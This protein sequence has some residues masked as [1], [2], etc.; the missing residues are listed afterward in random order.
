[1]FT[2]TAATFNWVWSAMAAITLWRTVPARSARLGTGRAVTVRV[3]EIAPSS[4]SLM[5]TPSAPQRT[6]AWR[7]DLLGDW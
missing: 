1:M 5:S 4:T 3:T 6:T 7:L 2:S